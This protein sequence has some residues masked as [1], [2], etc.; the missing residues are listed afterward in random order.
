MPFPSSLR[1]AAL[2]IRHSLRAQLLAWVTATLVCVLCFNLYFST[3]RARETANIV[4]DNMLLGSARMIA[5]AVRVDAGGNIEVDIPPAALE[6]FDTGQG[7]NV[8]YRVITAWGSLI[9]GYPDLPS[10]SMEQMGESMSFRGRNLR[11]MTIN[12][13]LVG[14]DTDGGINVTVAATN[15]GARAMRH[16]LLWADFESQLLLVVMA[17]IVTLIGLR[18]GLAPVMRLRGAVLASRRERLE[19]FDPD[20]VQTEIKPLVF[21]L[22]DYMQRIDGRWRRSGV[23]YRTPLTSCARR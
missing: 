7:D 17:G 14:L 22:N 1:A 5:E 11:A 6:M 15:N 20:M 19:P 4:T 23:S 10:P 21:A 3:S 18:V 2:G 16:R 8:Y 12:H 9:A 13:P